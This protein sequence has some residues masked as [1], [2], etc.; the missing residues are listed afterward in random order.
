MDIQQFLLPPTS[1]MQTTSNNHQYTHL[2]LQLCLR[3]HPIPSEYPKLKRR[4]ISVLS[5]THNNVAR[6]LYQD[7]RLRHSKALTH[8]MRRRREDA[9]SLIAAGYSKISKLTC[10]H[11]RT[12]DQRNAQ[13]SHAI[14]T[15]RVSRASTTK[16]ATP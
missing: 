6:P 5:N 16:I 4:P 3:D 2:H 13:L 11:I 7:T 10:S 1:W 15:S 14:T 9:Q 12:S 8:L